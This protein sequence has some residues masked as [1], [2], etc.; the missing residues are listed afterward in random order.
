MTSFFTNPPVCRV[1]LNHMNETSR[2]DLHVHSTAS[3]ISKLG[4]QRSLQIPECA[5]PPLEVYE[6][7]KRRRSIICPTPSSPRS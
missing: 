3:Q 2:A 6:L 7:A 4:V 5:T 1:I